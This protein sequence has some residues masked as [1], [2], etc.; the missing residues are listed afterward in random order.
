MSSVTVSSKPDHGAASF[1]DALRDSVI[2]PFVRQISGTIAEVIP[3][4][5][6]AFEIHRFNDAEAYETYFEQSVS[7]DATGGE[8]VTNA[9]NTALSV[10]LF[11]PER[12]DEPS[13]VYRALSEATSPGGTIIVASETPWPGKILAVDEW[14]EYTMEETAAALIRAGFKEVESIVEG[15]FFRITKALKSRSNAY[16][17]LIK[18]EQYLENGDHIQAETVLNNITEQMDSALIVREYALL[19]AACHDLAGRREHAL[20]ALSEALV[21]DPR[22][23]RAMCGLGRIAAIKGDLAS[24]RDF[25]QSALRF[26]PA[27]VAGLHGVAIIQEADG[28]LRNAYRSM[29]TASDLRPSNDTL[30]SDAARLGN[31]TGEKVDVAHFLSHRLGKTTDVLNFVHE[32]D[33][34]SSQIQS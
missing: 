34:P 30:L 32:T 16:R 2:F 18:A 4:N 13:K 1:R 14:G 33:G 11:G 22:C 27:L 3:Q 6:N 19:I 9:E 25:F 28:D 7:H 26:E 10:W 29:R 31:V 20:E 23:A 5:G 24:A 8:S 21:L 12:I 17:D 15:P